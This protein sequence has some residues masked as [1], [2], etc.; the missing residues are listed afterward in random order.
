MD[1]QALR[2]HQTV[3]VWRIDLGASRRLVDR[4]EAA[5]CTCV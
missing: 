1:S 3:K 4:D 5:Y 2:S